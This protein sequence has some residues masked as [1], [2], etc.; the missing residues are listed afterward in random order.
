MN[1]ISNDCAGGF[2]YK[3]C[4]LEFNNPFIW[5]RLQENDFYYTIKNYEK[6]NFNNFEIDK[7]FIDE[8]PHNKMD[9]FKLKIDDKIEIHYTHYHFSAK[10][11]KIRIVPPE[12]FYNK[13]WEYVVE[14]YTKRTKRMLELNE[15]PIFFVNFPRRKYTKNMRNKLLSENFKY[16]LIII[17]ENEEDLK[18]AND[19]KLILIDKV[20]ISSMEALP[21][22]VVE[23]HLDKI[24]EFINAD[25]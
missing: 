18:Y 17:T 1:L 21:N 23:R 25:N 2:V 10:D 9:I 3:F 6:I 24:K 5:M 19:D 4:N 16:K 7:S 13:I 15:K 12:I 22:K 8:R 20:D 11:N 14:K